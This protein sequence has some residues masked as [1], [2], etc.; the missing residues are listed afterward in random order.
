MTPKFLVLALST[1]PFA[2][3][4]RNYPLTT[5]ASCACYLTNATKPSYFTHHYFFDFRSQPVPSSTP[6]PLSTFESNAEAPPTS[7]YFSSPE[8]TSA[9]A[10]QSWNNTGLLALK[11]S[12][13]TDA[14]L[15][16]V[17]SANNIYFEPDHDNPNSTYLTM[18]TVRHADFQ[19]SAEFE[20]RATTYQFLSIRMLART[21]GPPGAVTAMFTYRPPPIPHNLMLVQE[22]DLEIRTSD[23]E[24][25]VSYTNQPSWNSTGDI[26]EA[27]RNVTLPGR[28]RWSEW[29]V[30]RMDWTPGSST[31]FVNGVMNG[32]I[33]FQA[34]R[35]PMQIMFNVWSDGGSWSGTMKEGES[36]KMQVQWI[37]LVYNS[38]ETKKQG[39]CRD[40]CS[41]D[42]T[43][44]TG[45]PVLM[46][47]QQPAP[48]A[49]QRPPAPAVSQRPPAPAG[50]QQ[51]A[52]LACAASVKKYDQCNGKNFNGCK[53]C[54][55]GTTCRFQ[56]DYYS[57][58]L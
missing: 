13:V 26:P 54:P 16:M 28:K 47:G 21:R 6:T 58:C 41:I 48:A 17:N 45:I 49:S 11:N 25:H 51:P 43:T 1:L 12:T 56:N 7:S 29:A 27:T 57:Q 8:W 52:P 53:G 3:S 42:E 55:S 33:K 38:T 18:R 36:A 4:Q 10:I 40:V 19:S 15:P 37:D 30:Y 24:T 5:D 23:P 46:S 32:E 50:S 35:D 39:G 22:A 34:P 20:S 14:S 2:L 44:K 31:W 9:W